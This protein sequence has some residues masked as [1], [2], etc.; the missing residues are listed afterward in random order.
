MIEPSR[1]RRRLRIT[2]FLIWLLGGC[3]AALGFGVNLLLFGDDPLREVVTEL[4]RSLN[5]GAVTLFLALS[6]A[7]LSAIA[8][9][10]HRAWR[11]R[12]DLADYSYLGALFLGIYGY[13]ITWT[14]GGVLVGVA[15]A[16]MDGWGELLNLPKTVFLTWLLSLIGVPFSA[17]NLLLVVP[18]VIWCW[19]RTLHR[20]RLR[21]LTQAAAPPVTSA[22]PS[23]PAHVALP[24]LP[25]ALPRRSVLVAWGVV[26]VSLVVLDWR[27]V[28]RR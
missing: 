11:N 24:A 27:R 21:A 6:L 5:D 13:V 25:S 20:A 26:G 18:Q 15:S 3:A 23:S 19:Q 7:G 2:L 17:V 10:C 4:P 12:A 9:V 28:K 16:F 8:F 22:Q 1:A 14:V